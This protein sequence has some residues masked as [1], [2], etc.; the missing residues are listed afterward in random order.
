MM[1]CLIPVFAGLG[2]DSAVRV[3]GGTDVSRSPPL[4]SIRLALIP[5]LSKMGVNLEIIDIKP[6]YY[7]VGKGYVDVKVHKTEEIRPIR[8]TELGKPNQVII[9]YYVKDN[10]VPGSSKDFRKNIKK[11][12]TLAFGEEVKIEFTV[13][14]QKVFCTK[15]D[16][17]IGCLI[18]GENLVWDIGTVG[19]KV[20]ENTIVDRLEHL[21]L[22]KCSLDEHHQDQLLIYAALAK[23]RS[24]LFVGEELSLHTHSLIY[25]LQ[26]FIPELVIS[27]ENGILSVEG[28]GL[29][30]V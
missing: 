8:I 14:A 13:K 22:K 11:L 30:L 19:E 28:I 27:H 23:G 16:Y 5:L 7:P 10:K 20:T 26:K 15:D 18:L 2:Y 21:I 17:G 6:G 3:N 1:Q 9:T 29:S 4:E 25:V 24:E 12:L